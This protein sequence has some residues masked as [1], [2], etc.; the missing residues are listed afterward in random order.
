MYLHI[1]E[2]YLHRVLSAPCNFSNLR[3]LDLQLKHLSSS[4]S[5]VHLAVCLG[6]LPVSKLA[7]ERRASF[8]VTS[9]SLNTLE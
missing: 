6:I 8:T 9:V 1:I 2:Y 4:C 3:T 5:A 7:T